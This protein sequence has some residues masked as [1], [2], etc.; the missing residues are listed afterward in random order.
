MTEPVIDASRTPVQPEW[1]VASQQRDFPEWHL[2]RPLYAVWAVALDDHDVDARLEHLRKD[3]GDL[4]FPGYVR[5]PHITV[6]VCGFPSATPSLPD[7]FSGE[8]LQAH[9]DALASGVVG[10]FDLSVGEG[11]TFTAA[12]CLAVQDPTRSLE[13]LRTAWQAVVP[14]WD[15]TPYRPHV[16]AGLYSGAWSM[17][18]IRARIAAGAPT[19]CLP[20]RIR[21][22]DW[23][24]YESGRIAGPLHTLLRFDLER[25]QLH[26]V[27]EVRFLA[28][29]TSPSVPQE[30]QVT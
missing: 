27:D 15:R 9:L 16:T 20:L 4:M 3:L 13:R 29:F 8:Q 25:C 7:D 28:V 5:Q 1:T 19:P 23:M 14:T 21:H 24:C 12:A 11:F 10:P 6:Q 17:D 26:V 30:A 2:G 18:G 22:V